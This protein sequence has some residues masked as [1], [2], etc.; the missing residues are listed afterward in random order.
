[1]TMFLCGSLSHST[2]QTKDIVT[3]ACEE[4]GECSLLIFT[5]F[6]DKLLS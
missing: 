1:M 4:G 6:S 2:N 3:F 5:E